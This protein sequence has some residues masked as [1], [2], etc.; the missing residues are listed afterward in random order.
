MG[1][2]RAIVLF[3]IDG[4]L[5]HRAGP[6]HKQAIIEAIRDVTAIETS[7]G[8]MPTGGK[9]DRD[10][11]RALLKGVGAK[12]REIDAWMPAIVERA[13]AG[14][15]LICPQLEDRVCPGVADFLH[16]LERASIPAGLVT[17]NLTAIGWKKVEAA[18][19]RRHFTVGAF[20]EMARTRAG[21]T[22]I[23]I[24][25]ARKKGLAGRQ[26]SF[27]LVGDHPNDIEAAKL[28]GIRSI[29][30]AT[31]LSTLDELAACKPDVLVADLRALEVD[32]LL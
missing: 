7:F 13:Q 32:F 27:S 24:R 18:G 29:A 11:I 3:D 31:G 1:A 20:S 2:A 25:E 28:N 19:L 23:A 8:D 4:T 12:K 17:G 21:L 6:H 15:Q 9:L 22:K 30:V 14:Y 26:T 5:L 16:R 10:L